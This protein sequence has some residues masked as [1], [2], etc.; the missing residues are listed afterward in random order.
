MDVVGDYKS[1]PPPGKYDGL[2]EYCTR[3]M[4]RERV[5]LTP[6]QRQFACEAF[7]T[8]LLER[9]VEVAAFC[10][11]AKHWHG[12]LRF[13]NPVKHRSENRDANRLIGQAKG[14]CAFEMS[15]AGVVPQGGV[16][17]AKCRVHPVTDNSHHH[18]IA[19]YIPSHA[20]NGAAVYVAPL[21]P[22]AKRGAL[23]P[24]GPF[25]AQPPAPR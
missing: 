24:G 1:P 16:W 20:K 14:K 18:N 10:V 13:R 6:A 12:L 5:V 9:E 11:G 2:H 3:L 15:R 23:A 7:V 22:V 21:P 8:A 19:R 17:A 25:C 4:R